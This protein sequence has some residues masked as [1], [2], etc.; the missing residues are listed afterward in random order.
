MVPKTAVEQER[1]RCAQLVENLIKRNEGT[2]LVREKLK[3]LLAKIRKPKS[4]GR[5]GGRSPEQLE[6][7]F[8]N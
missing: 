1:E 2:P 6:L 8:N 7:P 5:R 3:G 4:T